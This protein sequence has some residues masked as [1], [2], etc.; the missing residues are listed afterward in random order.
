VVH[1]CMECLGEQPILFSRLFL[2]SP[3]EKKKKNGKE[4]SI[5]HHFGCKLSFVNN[6]ILG[7]LGQLTL[8]KYTSFLCDKL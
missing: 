4:N 6:M 7:H 5:R 8:C 3:Y 2:G 1:S